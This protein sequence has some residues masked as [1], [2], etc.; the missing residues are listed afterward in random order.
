MQ[1]KPMGLMILEFFLLKIEKRFQFMLIKLLEN[2]YTNHFLI[3]LKITKII[4]LFLN[5]LILKKR[6]HLISH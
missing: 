6:F 4:Q 1:I 3:V 2:I 5:L